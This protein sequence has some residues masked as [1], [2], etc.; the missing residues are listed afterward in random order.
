MGT[1]VADKWELKITAN[2]FVI[3]EAQIKHLKK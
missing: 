3:G 1:V 2:S